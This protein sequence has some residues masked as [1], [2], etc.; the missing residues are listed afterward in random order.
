MEHRDIKSDRV[1]YLFEQIKSE[2]FR[3]IK[4][5]PEYGTFGIDVTLHQGEIT[6]VV[7]KNERTRKVGVK[8]VG[9]LHGM[10][11]YR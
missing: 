4:N 11:G 5:A 6:R 7:T 9:S 3:L 2:L 8:A 1:E 10:E